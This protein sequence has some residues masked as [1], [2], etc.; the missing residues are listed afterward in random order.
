[1]EKVGDG[2]TSEDE[3]EEVE[4]S[5]LRVLY[6]YTWIIYKVARSNNKLP[7]ESATS[8]PAVVGKR[9]Q[10]PVVS[11]ELQLIKTF[12]Y[13][14]RRRSHSTFSRGIPFVELPSEHYTFAIVVV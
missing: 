6:I 10:V 1:M 13:W 12:P 14:T 8:F 9:K 3:W 11:Y 2:Q 4:Y 7:G 5:Q